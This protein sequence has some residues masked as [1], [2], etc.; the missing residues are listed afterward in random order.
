MVLAPLLE[1]SPSASRVNKFVSSWFVPVPRESGAFCRA[2]AGAGHCLFPRRT[3]A[4][5]DGAALHP[6]RDPL[7]HRRRARLARLERALKGVDMVV[8]AAAL[9]QV[10]A[11]EYNP[12][13][14]IKTNVIGAENVINACLDQGVRKVV[15][16]STDKA[17][18][19]GQSLRRHQALLRQAVRRGQS[20]RRQGRHALLPW[21]A[22]AMS[23][24]RAAAVMPFFKERRKTGKSADHRPRA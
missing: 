24:A 15:A 9:K 21:C 20:P 23:S 8:H 13:E 22:T 18:E 17:V 12:I 5:R 7:F 14:C 1:L 2:S 4:V 16:L 6:R 10:P 11:A 3:Q 19:S